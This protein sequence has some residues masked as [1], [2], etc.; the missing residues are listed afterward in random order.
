LFTPHRLRLI[1]WSALIFTLVFVALFGY[2]YFKYARRVDKQLAAGP[3]LG[4]L[5]IYA[6]PRA[7]AVGD[8][9]SAGQ[10]AA[11]LRQ[12]GY[13][14][15]ANH[16][17]GWYAGDTGRIEIHPGLHSYLD[18]QAAALTFS[19]GKISRIEALPGGAE[20]KEYRLEPQLIANLTEKSRERRRLV[21]FRD[22]PK[23]LLNAVVSV[24]D[25]RFF[26][27]S[28]FD[29]IRILKAAYVDI[30]EG[31]KE[32]GASTLSMQLARNLWLTSDKRFRRKLEEL[33]IAMHLETR[34]T[35]EQIFEYY[36]NQIYLGRRGTFN[37]HGF[38]E[39]AQAF[40]GKDIRQLTLPESAT[41]AGI[42]Q[43]P[44][45]Y[46][47]FRHPERARERRNLVL[48]L[49][50]EN[51]YITPGE[52]QTASAADVKL[53]HD[54]RES[55]D[56][57][58]FVDLVHEEL[59][60]RL[61][62]EARSGSV[63]T[64]LD[65]RLQA[66]AEEAVKMGMQKV[67]RLTRKKGAKA[68]VALVALD[69]RSGEIKAL[70]GGREYAA[71][72][73]NRA[74]ARRQPGSVFKPFVFAAALNTAVAG[75]RSL[76]TPATTVL[77]EPTQWVFNQQVY[78]PKNY[79]G[80]FSGE[81]TLR[82]ALIKSLNIPTIKAAEMAGY[83]NIVNLALRAGFNKGVQATPAIALGAYEATPLEVAGAYTVFANGGWYVKPALV[84][85]VRAH[86]GVVAHTHSPEKRNA[87]DP[88]VAFL[89][90]D[91]MED[92]MRR[93]TGAGARSMG[94]R[95]PAA[96]KTGTSR[97]GWFA[98]FTT[99][100]LCVVWVGFDDNRELG[101]EGSTSA[102]PIWTEFMKRAHKLRGYENPKGFASPK[103]LVR[104]AVD[105]D[106]GL[107]AGPDCEASTEYF[108]SGT[109]PGEHCSHHYP[110][111]EPEIV[112]AAD[113]TTPAAAAAGALP[114][115]R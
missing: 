41:L 70:V 27:H 1:Q 111:Y 43:R 115:Q 101:L 45:Y 35:K 112:D 106:T 84:R 66:A 93:G 113:R 25:K 31:R 40:F 114:L 11:E 12:S 13:G 23:S 32:Q 69:P 59:S 72:Q 79:G 53:S 50:Q 78:E 47:P 46:D 97:D 34:L 80:T 75:G 76:M 52:Y 26:Q 30:R 5:N 8:A 85:R 22:M 61:A 73:L 29:P 2:F 9:G 102:L 60:D 54:Y 18:R 19:A 62:Q 15:S 37:I 16:P 77:D 65:L 58:Y 49:M 87:L 109:Q 108:I 105:P 81:V 67:D 20:L 68:E 57:Q 98:G 90:T 82:R 24:E 100:L 96:G 92:V 95:A 36:S 71:S 83:N 99:E 89:V 51:G 44:S 110:M 21:R 56:S 104:V 88:R 7:M 33:L 74:L 10:I 3:F 86:D 94:F 64:S 103:G 107:L 14:R 38:G 63:Y 39:A 42:I 17:A 28:G 91:M 55:L 48:R 6:A 4:T